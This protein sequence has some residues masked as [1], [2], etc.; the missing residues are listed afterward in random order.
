MLYR[1]VVI[2]LSLAYL[3]NYWRLDMPRS[4]IVIDCVQ[5]YIVLLNLS[6]FLFSLG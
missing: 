2:I 3:L 4:L 5:T 1:F 6:L